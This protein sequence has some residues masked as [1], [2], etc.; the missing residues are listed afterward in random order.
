MRNL[1]GMLLFLLCGATATQAQTSYSVSGRIDDP[2]MEGKKVYMEVY[3]THRHI[4]TATVRNGRF[5][6][7]GTADHPYFVRL[8]QEDRKRYANCILEDSV[9]IDL[10]ANQPSEGGPLTRK[11]LAY[12]AEKKA[13][14]AGTKQWKEDYRISTPAP[15]LLT[16][17]GNVLNVHFVDALSDLSIQIQDASG[18]LLHEELLSGS[19]GEIIPISLEG[20]PAGSYHVVLTHKLGWLSGEF[21]IN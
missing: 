7:V 8:E 14:S 5:R 21:T 18:T 17:E 2:E 13:L 9:T 3:D 19:M 10:T 12:Q 4:D 16:I 1:L 11:Y 6:F 15:P 20:W